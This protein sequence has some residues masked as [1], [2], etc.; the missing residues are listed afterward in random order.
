MFTSGSI[1]GKYEIADL[2]GTGAMGVVYKA[3]DTKLER[4]VAL[5]LLNEQYALSAEYRGRLSQEAKAAANI[6]S[7]YVV[8][9]WEHAEIDGQPYISLEY[10]PG[11]DLR[12]VIDRLDYDRKIEIARQIADGLT[13]AHAQGLIH[14]DLKPE[15]IKL[16]DGHQVKILDF[17]LAKTVRADSVDDHGN[18]EGTLYYLSPEQLTG[19][20]LSFSSDIFSYGVILYEMFTGQRP[21]EGEYPAA[22]IYSILHEDPLPPCEIDGDLPDWLGSLI[23]QAL[24]KQ[25]ADRFDEVGSIRELIDKG[26]QGVAAETAPP[27]PRHRQTVTVIDLQ[28]LSGD[29]NW[30]YFCIGFTEDL[31]NE[32]S[33]HTNLIISAE[34]STAFS[35]NVRDVFTR[36]RSDFVIVGSL[37][38]WQENIKL[39]L[40]VYSNK[41][42]NIILGNNY[43]G[44]AKEIFDILSRAVGDVSTSFERL[45]GIAAIDTEEYF[46]T[47]VAAYEYYLKGKN[48]YQTN[49][50]DDLVFAEQ[51]FK[52]AM[53]IDSGLAYAYSGLSDVYTFQYMMYY[54][55][56]QE[57]IEMA[58]EAAEKAIK[59][60]PRL[61]E[62]H[63][64]LGRCYMAVE[65]FG[66]AEKCFLTAVEYNPKYAIGYRTLAWLK[67]MS[68][69]H[70]DSIEYAK[71][72]LRYA[73]NDLETLMLLSLINM[74][75]RKYTIAMATLQ[76]AIEL[77]PDYGRAYHILGSVYL[78]LGVVDMALENFNLA[79]KYKGDPNAIVDS[80]FFYL[81]R[82]DYDTARKRF[83]ESIQAGYFPFIALYFL[84]LTEKLCGRREE[85]IACL[86]KALASTEQYEKEDPKNPH[87][88]S[89][90]AMT[91]AGLG[92]TEEAL[93]LARELEARD[94]Q[95]GSID[96]N[97]GRTYATLGDLEKTKEILRRAVTKRAGPT[98]KELRFDPHFEKIHSVIFDNET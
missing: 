43:D 18:I 36:C 94:Y 20:Q 32:L 50:P 47:D 9:V 84:A 52:K 56:T 16:K 5:K 11:A 38:K 4:Q 64:S 59:I 51:M 55:R 23:M 24:A 82:K 62:A 75:Q 13:A 80:G 79:I 53:E 93:A 27:C 48:Y 77:A 40:K 78:K 49:K 15:N 87:L 28:N 60:A 98:M 63:R 34:P 35:R 12:E 85:S 17:G 57:R 26:T 7:P 39:N 67:E 10:V 90:K 81:A 46:K 8:K 45:S 86:E 41:G 6:D 88:K 44:D 83:N 74:D 3:S 58:R 92:R 31:I 69:D 68:G 76:R 25:P 91:L 66:R 1:F 95:D 97:L 37:L 14:R 71:M 61:P 30:G 96:Q 29:E 19:E 33:R 2:L 22:I 89:F 54:E 21:F 65:D 42:D 72:A 70:T 73:P